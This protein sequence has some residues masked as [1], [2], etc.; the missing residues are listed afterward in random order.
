MN[1]SCATAMRHPVVVVALGDCG[2]SET[3]PTATLGLGNMHAEQLNNKAAARVLLLKLQG[4]LSAN[5]IPSGACSI[6]TRGMTAQP[7]NGF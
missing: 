4:G 5:R 1:W 6:G 3:R 7:L 2:K